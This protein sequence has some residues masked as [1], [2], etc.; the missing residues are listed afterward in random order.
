[1]VRLGGV[2]PFLC[3]RGGEEASLWSA[4]VTLEEVPGVPSAF[5]VPFA[6]GIPMTLRWVSRSVTVVTEHTGDPGAPAGVDWRAL[7]RADGI[8]VVL[9]G[10]ATRAE[11][12]RQLLDA[13]KSAD[14]PVAVVEWGTTP[15]PRVVSTT[16]DGLAGVELGSPALIVI[17]D[18]AGL[19]HTAP[20]A[21]PLA[22]A[23]VVVTRPEGDVDTLADAL[24]GAGAQVVRLPVIEIADPDDGGE[25]LASAA[26]N[27]ARYQW[28]AFTSANA[29]RR[30]LAL[31][32]D[33]RA[34]AGTQV[35]ALGPATAAALAHFHVSPDLVADRA[36]AEGL[37]DAFPVA[38]SSGAAV[39]FPS[40]AG[41][42]PTLPEALRAKGWRVDEVV[43][44]RTAPAR[45]PDPDV[46]RDLGR[47]DAVTFASPSA[48]EAYASLRTEDGGFLPVPP[49]VACIGP[50]TADAA[51][52]AGFEVAVVAARASAASLVDALVDALSGVL[53]RGPEVPPR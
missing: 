1:M 2:D 25:A 46:L 43:A 32:P 44:Y 9:K 10:T 47:A 28:V 23:R 33:V 24:R 36:S 7:A 12:S 21:G 39:L 8:L 15:A 51:R 38:T 5:A 27:L 22:G 40:S 20:S 35:A 45:G 18:V 37:G 53:A 11:I 30:L 17:G 26:A 42:R 52:A 16:L 19:D 31:V 41:A 49:V 3:A 14:T 4:G 50:V 48:V 34:L 13:G 6:A 29:V